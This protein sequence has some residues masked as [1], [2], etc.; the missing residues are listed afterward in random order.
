MCISPPPQYEAAI[1][2]LLQGQVLC[3]KGHGRG[4]PLPPERVG[5]LGGDG[6]EDEAEDLRLE[7]G[8]RSHGG[9]HQT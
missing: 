7:D 5:P 4:D 1:R 3:G 8:A 9:R 2:R 6:R